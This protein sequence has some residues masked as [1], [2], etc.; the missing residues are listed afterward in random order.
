[1]HIGLIGG[2]G[3]AATLSYYS[4]LVR[5]YNA[6]GQVMQLTIAHADMGAMVRNLEAGQPEAQANIFAAHVDEL[7][8]AGCKAVAVTSM[9]G[10]FCIQQLEAIS[11]LPVI[12]AL[13]ALNAYFPAKGVKRIGVLGTRMVTTSK[14]Y[15]GVTSIDVIPPEDP[16]AVH[17]AYIAVATAASATPDLRAYFHEEGRKLIARGADVV[18]LAGTDLFVAFDGAD[19]GYPVTDSTAVHVEAIAQA[20]MG[21]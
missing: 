4:G 2:I 3:P 5:A 19:P 17:A 6:A 9:G 13:P 16:V 1:M 20:G 11:S 15:G 7:K 10:H 8:A 21:S 18:V 12:N 14:F